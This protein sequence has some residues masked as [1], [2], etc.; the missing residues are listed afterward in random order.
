MFPED[1]CLTKEIKQPIRTFLEALLFLFFI[2]LYLHTN[3]LLITTVLITFGFFY[4]LCDFSTSSHK[5]Q[6][7]CLSDLEKVYNFL[8]H[9][10]N[11]M[12]RLVE[13]CLNCPLTI[14]EIGCFEP[15]I[16]E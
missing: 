15:H 4:G 1:P 5:Q 8:F 2:A 3:F 14:R 13:N 9:K 10:R 7:M 16:W 6:L 11:F 12:Y